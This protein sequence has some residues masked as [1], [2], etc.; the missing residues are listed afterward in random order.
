MSKKQEHG[1]HGGAWKV[2][3]ADFVTAMMALFIV[4]WILGTD[5]KQKAAVAAYFRHPS[6]LPSGGR[7]YLNSEGVI[8]LRQAIEK[9]DHQAEAESAKTE[10][11]GEWQRQGPI[12]PEELA[13]RGVLAESEKKLEEM[14]NSDALR[15]L[16]GQVTIEYTPQ[17]MRI[18]IKD[19]NRDP[20]FFLGEAEPTPPARALLLGI[21]RVLQGLPNKILLEG[22]TDQRPYSGKTNY[23]NWELSG[24]RA[25]AAR[26]V[27]ESGGIAPERIARVIGYGDRRLLLPEDPFSDQ[28]RRI[29]IIVCYPGQ[30]SD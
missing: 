9:I 22:H 4:L 8:E 27:L 11:A 24:D 14:L 19:L 18:Q 10:M 28:N 3:Y 21:A 29:S 13:E 2:A 15:E 16:K 17:G 26:R 25:N 7:G 23:S 1:Y 5:S 20:L 6:I 12:T 30:P